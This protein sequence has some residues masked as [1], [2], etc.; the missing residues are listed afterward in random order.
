MTKK[1]TKPEKKEYIATTNLSN[2]KTGKDYAAGDSV[3]DGDFP[4][5]VIKNWLNRGH[6][7]VRG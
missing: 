4:A 2:S 6:L 3:K 1:K 5:A 7:E